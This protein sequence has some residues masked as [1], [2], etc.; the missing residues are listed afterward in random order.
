[1]MQRSTR[2]SRWC[3]YFGSDYSPD[4]YAYTR[5]YA[6]PRARA[7]TMLLQARCVAFVRTGYANSLTLIRRETLS[8]F[9]PKNC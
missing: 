3:V 4:L 1:M 7:E 8:P 5:A 9:L 6:H 2:V